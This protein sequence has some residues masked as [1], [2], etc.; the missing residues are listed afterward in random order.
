[1]IGG[2][3]RLAGMQPRRAQILDL[4]DWYERQFIK[5]GVRLRLNTFLDES[6]IALHPAEVV[7]FATGSLP[8]ET[9]FQRW[10]PQ[11][12]HLPGI[13]LAGVWS[14]E[15]VMRREARIGDAV[16]IY[17]EGSN[18]RGVGTAWALAEQGKT[19]TIVTPE[20]FVGKE[21]ART[22]ADGPARRRLAQLGV[23]M[24]TEHCVS[25]WHGNGVTLRNLLTGEETTLPTS[26]LVMSTTNRAFDPW[27]DSFK[28]KSTYKIGDCIAPRLA[29]YAF[30]E[31]RKLA[32]IL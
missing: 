17:D 27:P 5:L 13:E 8:D 14:P 25:R 7:I 23:K 6:E 30:H 32:R 1:M 11:E 9:G 18:W 15:A 4:M 10:M 24:L 28:G 16:V 2:Q 22:A 26:A 3:F 21:I 19:V 20:A 29:A 31:G 12:P